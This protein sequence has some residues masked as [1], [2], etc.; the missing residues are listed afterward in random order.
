MLISAFSMF[1]FAPF[2]VFTN[3][4]I[5]AIVFFIIIFDTFLDQFLSFISKRKFRQPLIKQP[6]IVELHMSR[7]YQFGVDM[8]VVS[9]IYPIYKWFLG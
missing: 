3:E 9:F 7:N 8:P 1:Q 5:Y 2:D 4:N 6:P